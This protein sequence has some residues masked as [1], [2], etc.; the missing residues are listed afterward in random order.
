MPPGPG[1]NFNVQYDGIRRGGFGKCLV[2]EDGALM[3]GISAP[4]KETPRVRMRTPGRGAG[5]IQ[6][7]GLPSVTMLGT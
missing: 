1:Q 4:T 3:N 5:C 2:Q 7:E 6:E